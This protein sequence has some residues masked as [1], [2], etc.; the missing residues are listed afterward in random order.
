MP[1]HTD[2]YAKRGTEFHLWIER[3]FGE[4]TLFDE[5]LFDPLSYDDVPLKELQDKW[6]ASSWA[7]RKPHAVEEGFETVINGIVLRGRIDAVYRD[8]DTYEVVDWK[9]GRVKEGEDLETASI[10]LAMYR[11]AYSK[12]H[13]IPIEKIRAAFHYVADNKTIYRENLSSEDEIA[14]LING[15]E[16]L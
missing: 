10:Q 9:T 15:V 16:L 1:R 13:N 14:A 5:D 12:Q 8:G 3:H 6:L 11:L 7:G 2:K 4:L